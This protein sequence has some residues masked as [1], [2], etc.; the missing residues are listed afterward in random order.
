MSRI[1]CTVSKIVADLIFRSF[2]GLR[3]RNYKLL[4]VYVLGVRPFGQLQRQLAHKGL[5]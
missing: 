2:V 4:H 3:L 5:L 1:D